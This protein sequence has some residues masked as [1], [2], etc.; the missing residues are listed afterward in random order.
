MNMQLYFL[1]HA[2]AVPRGTP[3]Y[4]NDDRPLTEEGILKMKD[5]AQGI[6]RIVDGFTTILSSPLK[7]AYQTAEIVAEALGQKDRLD[8]CDELLPGSSFESLRVRLKK[9]KRN[10][11]VLLVG[12]EPDMGYCAS[13]LLGSEHSVIQFKK[14]AMCRIDIESFMLHEPGILI[15]HLAPK[16]LRALRK[17]K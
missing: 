17:V 16:H 15:W 13:A 3:G 1:R 6:S 7:R 12:H 8:I 4:P 9:I 5:E 14:G 11:S 10:S 2:I